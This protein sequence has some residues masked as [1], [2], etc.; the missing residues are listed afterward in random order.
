MHSDRLK[1][2]VKEQYLEGRNIGDKFYLCT[3]K[4]VHAHRK[5]G[6]I[7]T[8]SELNDFSLLILF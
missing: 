7:F 2:K 3:S 5:F 1:K 4:N 8:I 6:R